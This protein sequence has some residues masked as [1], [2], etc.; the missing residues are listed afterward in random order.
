[1]R[2]DDKGLF[3]PKRPKR[4]KSLYDLGF[5]NF[6]GKREV[7]RLLESLGINEN[8]PLLLPEYTVILQV[9]REL[10]RA[11]SAGEVSPRT[12]LFSY[13]RLK[14]SEG[15]DVICGRIDKDEGG[16]EEYCLG[17]MD[18]QASVAGEYYQCRKE[19]DKH[20]NLKG[21]KERS[22]L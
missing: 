8:W 18:L 11:A 15:R 19:A 20:R 17:I 2:N 12:V 22:F 14:L 13:Q 9:S 16:N 1:M 7:T 3:R 4:F 21:D 5:F 6:L 10:S